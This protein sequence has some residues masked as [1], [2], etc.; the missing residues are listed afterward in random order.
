MDGPRRV[1]IVEMESLLL[2]YAETA[3]LKCAP[4]SVKVSCINIPEKTKTI[5]CHGLACFYNT[6][7]KKLPINFTVDI[8]GIKYLT[9]IYM[10]KARSRISNPE[11]GDKWVFQIEEINP[12][13]G[14]YG[15]LTDFRVV[16]PRQNS[17][18]K[19]T[20]PNSYRAP[21]APDIS[22]ITNNYR[23][24]AEPIPTQDEPRSAS[25]PKFT[26]ELREKVQKALDAEDDVLE[27]KASQA[28]KAIIEQEDKEKAEKIRKN[29]E[30]EEKLK[31]A[32]REARLKEK[33]EKK[34]AELRQNSE[35]R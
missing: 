21:S 14:E 32:M 20:P 27:E 15:N 25:P 22:Q 29:E 19:T 9:E 30:L 1:S 4:G 3:V 12:I 11:I 8:G 33:V 34:L 28:A 18:S 31:A 26:D 13:N 35:K 7:K 6:K 16:L 17:N 23:N 2:R 10:E 5:P 24:I